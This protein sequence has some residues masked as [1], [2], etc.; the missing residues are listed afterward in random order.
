MNIR[1]T[2]RQ[3]SI[4]GVV[5]AIPV[6]AAFAAPSLSGDVIGQAGTGAAASYSGCSNAGTSCSTVATGGGFI[7]ETVSINGQLYYRTVV[8]E[9]DAAEGN[10][11]METFVQ[12]GNST[13]HGIL[14]K[15]VVTGA[16]VE[17]G[18]F[19]SAL[20][21]AE[22]FYYDTDL[23]LG[24][25]N[26]NA[27]TGGVSINSSANSTAESFNSAFSFHENASDF[28]GINS[29]GSLY[30]RQLKISTHQSETSGEIGGFSLTDLDYSGT[31]INLSSNE[32]F[33]MTVG[34]NTFTETN[35]GDAL[36]VLW[37]GQNLG[38]TF[39]LEDVG[40][41]AGA[42]V[43]GIG[44]DSQATSGFSGT[45]PNTAQG[46]D[47]STGLGTSPFQPSF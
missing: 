17:G 4:A 33:T 36:R 12:G 26:T 30:N 23:A 27:K 34:G 32:S 20:G 29:D 19:A 6:G 2:V 3:I 5:A 14:A 28:G 11:G 40:V 1:N 35:V 24:W 45:S 8:A 38:S 42:T 41:G 15:E 10:F 18:G 39:G 13:V 25:A 7:Q 22:G 44:N 9:T 47:W 37:L 46:F 16:A 31:A 43:T 21:A